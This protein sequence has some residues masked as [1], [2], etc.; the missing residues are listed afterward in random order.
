[1][2]RQCFKIFSDNNMK[3][4]GLYRYAYNFS[5]DF[6]KIDVDDTIYYKLF[7]LMGND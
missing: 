3:K 2:F 5:G 4:I 1:M 6:D 7:M